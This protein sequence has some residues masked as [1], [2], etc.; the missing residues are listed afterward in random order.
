MKVFYENS[1]Y[2]QVTNDFEPILN[3]P[4]YLSLRYGSWNSDFD[5]DGSLENDNANRV[6]ATIGYNFTE[7][8]GAS[9][10][11]LSQE[12]EKDN[13]TNTLVAQFVVSF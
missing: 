9:V 10:E 7:S 3:V 13:R 1:Y 11:Y 12:Y 4:V 2:L 5:Y 8:L 6:T